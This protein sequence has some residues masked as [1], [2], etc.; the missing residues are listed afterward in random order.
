MATEQL[1]VIINAKD[2]LSQKLKEVNNTLKQTGNV[3]NSASSIASNATNRISNAYSQLQ[4][5]VNTVFT[6]IKNTIKNSTAGNLI[7]ESG[8]VQ[9]FKNAAEKI[10][11][12]WQ[13]MIENLKG[14]LRGLG[15]NTNV[16]FNISPTG[17]AMLDGQIGSTTS[18]IGQLKNSFTGLKSSLA[19][20]GNSMRNLKNNTGSLGQGFSILK[21]ALAGVVGM[22]GYNLVSGMMEGV[23]ATINARGN[24]EAFARRLRLSQGEINN[25]NNQLKNY[26]SQFRKV[27]MQAVGATALELGNKLGVPTN[28]LGDLARMTAVMSS[29]FI[30]DGRTSEDAILAVSDA[31]DGQFRRLQEIGISQDMLKAKGWNGDLEDTAGLIDALNLAM[32]D[33]GLTATAM[34]VTNLD[35]AWQVLNVSMSHLLTEILIPLTPILVGLIMAF[36]DAAEAIGQWWA[37]L[38]DGAKIAVLSFAIGALAVVIGSELYASIL[39]VDAATIAY[40][41]TLLPV[42]VTI[43]E[44]AAVIAIVVLAFY[45]LGK[46]MGWWTDGA[47]AMQV[48]SAALQN[49]FNQLVACLQTVYNGFMEV[50]N[51]VIQAF[52]K[53]LQKEVQPLV[54]AFQRLWNELTGLGDAFGGASGSGS[55]FADIGRVIG[56]VFS[57][58]ITVLRILAAVIV[59]VVTFIVNIIASVIDFLT[60]LKLALDALMAGDILGFITI[61]GTALGTLFL[62]IIMNIGQLFL[63][64]ISNL[65]GMIGISLNLVYQ[66][67]VG[68]VTGFVSGAVQAV[69]GFISY[70]SQLPG[71]LYLW[72]LNAWNRFNTW[73][74]QVL[75]GFKTAASNAVNGFISYIQSLPSKLWTWLVNTYNK[76]VSFRNTLVQKLKDAAKG[77]V[78]SFK[79]KISSL[80]TVMWNEL[81]NIKSKIQN[82]AGALG[83]AIKNLG[84]TLLNNF[85]S[86]LGI[87]SPGDMSKAIGAEMVYIGNNITG[88]YST[89]N[90]QAE[91][92]GNTILD[93]FTGSGAGSITSSITGEGGSIGYNV[94]HTVD[95]KVDNERNELLKEIIRMINDLQINTSSVA[96]NNNLVVDN[97]GEIKLKH[98]LTINGLPDGIDEDTVITLVKQAIT[99]KD[100]IKLLTNSREFQDMDK[101]FKTKILKEQA[102]H[103]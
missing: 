56:S 23:R 47:S 62:N 40:Y 50:V 8:L 53:E 84:W 71:Q 90:R 52:W 59:P 93:G 60:Q 18:K 1:Q 45:E 31:L 15:S 79:S 99:E 88:A 38:P 67:I 13:T 12:T 3:A 5:R 77:A 72:L 94:T 17:L 36:A 24:I 55:L 100:T 64:I 82:A 86:A 83:S 68:L 29:A 21:G 89:L 85:K 46:A 48:I 6:N 16:G 96:N 102:R 4:N 41:L 95:N 101:R 57:T 97:K 10:R 37:S 32:D 11:N 87:A 74:L 69:T 58:T 92:L 75:Q 27:D 19:N 14:K 42:I 30:R 34:Q 73:R 28:K 78:D 63:N 80:P 43:A 98:E 66:W 20:V 81:M 61:L 25:F 70:I 91:Q 51:P 7:K 26:Q 9:P 2:M 22:L 49:A 39:A 35:D 54:A 103:I 65:A 76:V 44:I 33:L